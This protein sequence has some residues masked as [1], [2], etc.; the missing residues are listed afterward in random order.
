MLKVRVKPSRR[1]PGSSDCGT[2]SITSILFMLNLRGSPALHYFEF[3]A[4][5]V[6]L[7]SF[8]SICAQICLMN[9]S[10]KKKHP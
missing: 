8:E 5:P 10:K 4:P 7:G 2:L 1:A 9:N 3:Q 6:C